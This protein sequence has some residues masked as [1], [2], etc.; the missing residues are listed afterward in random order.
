MD[1]LTLLLAKVHLHFFAGVYPP[2]LPK[3]YFSSNFFF[4]TNFFSLTCIIRLPLFWMVPISVQKCYLFYILQ[5][6]SLDSSSSFAIASFLSLL[7][8]KR[9]KKKNFFFPISFPLFSLEAAPL[10]LF[11]SRSLVT[12]VHV[13]SSQSSSYITH[14]QHG[15]HR[16]GLH[17][18]S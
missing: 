7:I 2:C 15:A 17:G 14:Q 11:L 10:K 18:G 13:A 8:A 12:S 1:G 5:T 6:F 16:D 4:P 3:N 9:L